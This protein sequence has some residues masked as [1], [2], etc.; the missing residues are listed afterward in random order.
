MDDQ[1]RVAPVGMG[2]IDFSIIPEKKEVSGM[3]YYIVEQDRTFDGMTPF[4][5][6]K[7]S[8]EELKKIDF[9]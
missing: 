9:K 6:I 2:N 3:K 5:A 4:E 7:I 8:H 1:G